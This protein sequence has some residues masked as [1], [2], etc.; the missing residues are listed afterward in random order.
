MYK[1]TSKHIWKL[2]CILQHNSAVMSYMSK[3]APS[4]K[5]CQFENNVSP[6]RG[7]SQAILN[8]KW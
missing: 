8:G 6:S 3:H 1:K 5:G 2:S 7:Y 4:Y